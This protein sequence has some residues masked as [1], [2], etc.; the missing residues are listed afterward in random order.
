[1]PT[2]GTFV[3][4]VTRDDIITLAMLSLGK[5]GENEVP[6][7]QETTDCSTFLNMMVKQWM[8]KQDFAPGLKM[9]TRRRGNLF[10]SST[11]GKYNLGPS[12]SNWTDD[13]YFTFTQTQAQIGG[14]G[15]IQ[16]SPNVTGA[17][18]AGTTVLIELDSGVLWTSTVTSAGANVINF[19]PAIPTSAAIGNSAFAYNTKQTRPLTLE[20]AVL[21]DINNQ[22]IPLNF[23]TLKDYEFL[24]SKAD[25]NFISDPRAV[26]YEAQLTN[27]V[28]YLDVG[29]CSDV[30]KH[31]HAVY[32]EPVEDF[33]NPTDNPEYPQQWYMALAWGLAKQIA[34]MFNAP[35]TQEM[36][37]N[38][39]D[40]L[41]MAKETEPETD[42]IY[43]QPNQDQ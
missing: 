10:L 27:G 30:T 3:Y 23:M 41:A 29:G 40:A 22:D 4:S 18:V 8:G 38:F 43:F 35:W 5:L 33:N 36:Q 16:V 1:M 2:S 37:G 14:A 34:P 26:Y 39:A 28:L 21:R 32:L 15:T 13:N 12:G 17:I 42:T 19:N 6:T 7:A 31:I 20:T 24:P 9:W 11:T 25:P